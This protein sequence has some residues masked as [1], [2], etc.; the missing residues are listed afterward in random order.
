MLNLKIKKRTY[1]LITIN[2]NIKSAFTSISDYS[3]FLLRRLTCK[4]TQQ[5]L[6]SSQI[7]YSF[8]HL[9]KVNTKISK[10]N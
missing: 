3:N 10:T 6:Y 4:Y 2:S 8:R 9:L 7:T 1:T 5:V